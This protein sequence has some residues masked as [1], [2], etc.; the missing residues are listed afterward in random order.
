[1]NAHWITDEIAE[2][3]TLDRVV[4]LSGVSTEL[5]RAE[6]RPDL[7]I[8]AS[9]DNSVHLQRGTYEP[10]LVNPLRLWGADNGQYAASRPGGRGFDEAR[11]LGWL[12]ALPVAGCLFATLPDVLEWY[13]DDETGRLFPVGNLD[14]TLELSARYVD[15]V[16]G[17]GFPAALVAQDGLASLD[18]IPFDVD[19]IFVGGSDAYKLGTEAAGL[20]AEARSRGLW[21]HVGRV[22]SFRRLDY[23]RSIGADSADGTFLRFCR[24]ADAPAQHARMIGW[25]DRIAPK[26]EL[27]ELVAA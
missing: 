17:M 12:G 2:F 24:K 13:T 4:Y 20:V 27:A 8:L 11:W 10:G 15:Q 21:V 3:P 19:A 1:M 22:N 16:K 5:T 18:Q 9:P 6:S 25:L 7:G 14:A 23:A 26:P